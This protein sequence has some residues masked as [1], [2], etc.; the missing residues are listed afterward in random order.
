MKPDLISKILQQKC[1]RCRQGDVFSYN[2][3]LLRVKAPVMNE[4]CPHCNHKFER[5]S[6]FFLGA[7]Y[8]CY[9]IGVVQAMAVFIACQ[10][11]FEDTFDLR[12]IL[13]EACILPFFGL[14]NFRMGRMIWIYIFNK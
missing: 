9:A 3:S 11:V 5:E 2:G 4:R 14:F 7:M 13:V 10:F 8:A 12:I 6:G 1:P